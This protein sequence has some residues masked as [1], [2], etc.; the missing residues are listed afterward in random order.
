[1]YN[2]LAAFTEE[3]VTPAVHLGGTSKEGLKDPLIIARNAVL[4][5][6]SLLRECAP[7]GRDYYTQP[8]PDAY[9]TAARQHNSRMRA[10]DVI[11]RQLTYLILKVDRQ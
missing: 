5:A 11:Q 7:H 8:D 3:I 9:T 2:E 1:M 4:A 6:Q 10:L